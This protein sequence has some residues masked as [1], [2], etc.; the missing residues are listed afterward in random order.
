MSVFISNLKTSIE[1]R[2]IIGNYG[3]DL[4]TLS[5]LGINIPSGFIIT[6]DTYFDFLKENNLIK[7]INH[8]LENFDKNIH[9][10]IISIIKESKLPTQVTREVFKQY[11]MLGWKDAV[12][13]LYPSVPDE[14]L[15]LSQKENVKG[16]AV[17]IEEIKQ[18]W[19]SFFDKELLLH[20]QHR[21][22]SHFKTGIAII[23]MEKITPKKSGYIYCRKNKLGQDINIISKNKL[24]DNETEQLL[25]IG[26][27]ITNHHY[28]SKKIKW[29]LS[30]RKFYAIGISPIEEKIEDEKLKPN[31]IIISTS[32]ANPERIATG[33]VRIIQDKADL[34]NNDILIISEQISYG[35][36]QNLRNAKALILEK[37][38]NN[39]HMKIVLSQ[40]G[41]PVVVN[42]KAK[43]LFR[44]GMVVTVDASRD[45]V[46][47][48]EFK[49]TT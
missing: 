1:D 16:E 26:Q 18:I 23:V 11:K 31:E 30:G 19:A 47:P 28:F 4:S 42:K 20:R 39:Q 7:K 2:H 24:I 21:E 29:V 41:F 3:Y 38:I 17:L 25:D 14:H 45:Q 44:N 48:G 13:S 6:T 5:S 22:L 12:V 46:Y 49:I 27:K 32:C 36:L 34:R 40:L 33:T 15:K 35:D 37:E 43:S 8:L 9:K 10:S